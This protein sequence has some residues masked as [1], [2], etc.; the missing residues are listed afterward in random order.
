M[1]ISVLIPTHR[2]PQELHRCLEALKKQERRADQI[3]V[4]VREDDAETEAFLAAYHAAPFSI[5]IVRLS[6][7]GVIAAMNAGLAEVTGDIVALTDDDTV[8]FPDWLARIDAHFAAGPKVGGVG[9]RDWLAHD[10]RNA[11]V[12]GKV[13]WCGRLIGNHHQGYG[14]AREVDTLKGVN[15]AYQVEPL[16]TIG[17]DTRLRGTGAQ[18]HWELSL[19]L[20]MKNA[21]WQLIYD[22]EVALDHITGPR[23]DEDTTHRGIFNKGGTSNAAYNETLILLTFLSPIRKIAFVAWAFLLGTWGA[24]GVLQIPRLIAR[25]DQDFW[26]RMLATY[27]GRWDALLGRDVLS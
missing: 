21:G 19:G 25:R 5:K 16:R 15:C 23:F 4:T 3:V 13:Q 10:Q 6:A 11:A 9:G 22:P 14:P 2:R 27:A 18:V 1:Q 7:L 24:P 8:P 20:A 17:F 26:H 12:V